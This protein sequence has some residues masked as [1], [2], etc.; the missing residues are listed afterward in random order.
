VSDDEWEPES[1]AVPFGRPDVFVGEPSEDQALPHDRW[2]PSE[3]RK[4]IAGYQVGVSVVELARIFNR[5][6]SAIESRLR[7]LALVLSRLNRPG[8]PEDPGRC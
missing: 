6:P 5:R 1:F 7:T 2:T 4:L 3:D 8:R